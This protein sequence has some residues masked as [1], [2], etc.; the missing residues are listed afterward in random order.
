MSMLPIYLINLDRSP[1]RLEY[2][3]RRLAAL[4]LSFNRIPAVDGAAL[5]EEQRTAFAAARPR[6]GRGWSAGQIGCFLSHFESWRLIAAGDNPWA[7]V[8]EDDL[9]LSDT[10]PA[11]ITD[12]SVLDDKI[13]IVRLEST[14]QWL[15]L[16]P[17]AVTLAGRVVRP[18][19]SS[20]W[21]AGAY[22]ISQ[23]AAARLVATET[24][25]HTPTDDFLFNRP[26]SR[27]AAA[28]ATHQLVPAI[29]TQDKFSVDAESV[30]GF[31]SEIEIGRINQRLRGLRA[32]RRSITSSLR[33]KTSVNFA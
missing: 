19:R 3:S 27:V 5:S 15:A 6:D 30:L 10:L 16:G 33:G 2:I 12:V 9:H 29:A 1:S 32:V 14:G 13:D 18:L 25:L 7:L 26:Q 11:V 20:A 4:G 8:L 17:P 31:G 28:L 21:G 22:M 23:A 24:K